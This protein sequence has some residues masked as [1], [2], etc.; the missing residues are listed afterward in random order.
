M[1][2]VFQKSGSILGKSYRGYAL[3]LFWRKFDDRNLSE[4]TT[5]IATFPRAERAFRDVTD[6]EHG[7]MATTT[8]RTANAFEFFFVAHKRRPLSRMALISA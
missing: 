2:G 4:S 6:I 5:A 1:S 3:F 8:F 7:S